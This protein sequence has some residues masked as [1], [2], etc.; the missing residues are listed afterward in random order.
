VTF[1]PLAGISVYSLHKAVIVDKQ[2]AA[3]VAGKFLQANG[4]E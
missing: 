4:L 2:S 3:S 1:V